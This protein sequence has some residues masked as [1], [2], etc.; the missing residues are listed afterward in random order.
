MTTAAATTPARGGAIRGSDWVNVAIL[1]ALAAVI[2]V[3]G[4]YRA[5]S[6]SAYDEATH[7]DYVWSL[8][9]GRIPAKGDS[10]APEVLALWSCLGQDNAEDLPSCDAGPHDP[11]L[12]PNGGENYNFGH[13]PVYYG[14]SAL[15]VRV[16]DERSLDLSFVTA[17]RLTGAA[18]LAAGLAGCYLVLR[19]WSVP[20]VIALTSGVLIASVPS[21]AHASST[22]NNDAPAV[23]G[24]ALAFWVL[25]R[26]VVL[27]RLGWVVP[28][29]LAAF[30]A[31]TKLM[32]SVSMLAVAGF[33]GL[34]ALGLVRRDRARAASLAL[35]V[36]GVVGATL[37]VFIGWGWFQESRGV[38]VWQNPVLGVNSLPVDGD[39][40]DEWLPTLLSVIG[41]TKDF[42]L[43]DAL[44]SAYLIASANV[45]SVVL[46][47]A[48]FMNIAASGRGDRMRNVS[49]V[50][51][52]G[53]LAVPLIVQS[54]IYLGSGY[55]FPLVTTRYGV[56]LLPLTVGALALVVAAKKWTSGYVVLA[57]SA[58]V[59]L[60]LSFA[61]AL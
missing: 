12:Y 2:V 55:Y 36:A 4:S 15:V 37:T 22:V 26:I 54:Q 32:T 1:V 34:M 47:A 44:A 58:A 18:W 51:L 25:T 28:A 40:I 31:S 7:I 27:D 13:P 50:A 17:A 46:T 14:L 61:G 16:A 19:R 5:P 56:S 43:Q 30:V 48:P 23:L 11:G 35:I 59:L 6:L 20:R 38:E 49:W 42:W 57:V 53:V 24:G 45:L 29:L 39:P 33:V 9:N 60:A 41:I 3:L 21:V 52:I 10:L 8:A